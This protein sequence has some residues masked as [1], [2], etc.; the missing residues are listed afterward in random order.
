MNMD[1]DTWQLIAIGVITLIQVYGPGD[2]FTTI[3]AK[4]WDFL[5]IVCKMLANVLDHISMQARLNYFEA[6]TNGT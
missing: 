6:V 4:I 3:M 2:G 5:A 1:V